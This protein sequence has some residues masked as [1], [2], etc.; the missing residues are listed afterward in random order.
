[1]VKYPY[2]YIGSENGQ[3]FKIH[4]DGTLDETIETAGGLS[5]FTVLDMGELKV[6]PAGLD[7]PYHAP[8]LIDLDS[9]GLQDTVFFDT[10]QKVRLVSSSLN[11][12]I[13]LDSPV[14][15][16]PAFGDFD[17]DGYYELFLSTGEVLY[18]F[19]FNRAQVDNFPL[20]PVLQEGEKITGTPLVLDIDGDEHCD[21]ALV[22]T[23]GQI[24]AYN[25]KGQIL[26]GFPFTAGAP[27]RGSLAAGDIDGDQ[28]IELFAG[29]GQELFA[30]Q[31]SVSG[32]EEQTWWMQATSDPTNNQL[33]RRFLER[34]ISNVP[35]LLP[36][37]KAY[38]YPNPNTANFTNIR[39]FL[40]RDASVHINIFD[41]AGDL[42]SRFEGPGLGAVDNEIRWQLDG[43]SSG[44]YLCRI[45]ADSQNEQAVQVIKIMVIK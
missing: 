19:H 7:R 37:A 34:K 18:G 45:E 32:L 27:I 36:A 2:V 4:F 8:V 15:G 28:K 25:Y 16:L 3:I 39:Y 43:V 35:E 40:N 12:S 14:T 11:E 20:V 10:G 42:V 31:L 29:N 9:D 44:I 1:V 38:V 41:L 24:Y 30:W 21:V 6:L 17:L 5:G 22:T 26:E 33:I 23:G 13:E